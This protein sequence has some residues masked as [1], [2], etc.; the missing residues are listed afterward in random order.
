MPID[1]VIFDIICPNS[2]TRN[3]L[4]FALL[5]HN[6][7]H[8]E[9]SRGNRSDMVIVDCEKPV[10]KNDFM[11]YR[12]RFPDCPAILLLNSA[13]DY[14]DFPEECRKGKE[15]LLLK[16]FLL[17]DLMAIVDQCLD[18]VNSNESGAQASSTRFQVD[19]K[20]SNGTQNLPQLT[21]HSEDSVAVK[22]NIVEVSSETNLQQLDNNADNEEF[23]EKS[24]QGFKFDEE[25][26]IKLA[27]SPKSME[28][29]K[30][31]SAKKSDVAGMDGEEI[32]PFLL[33]SDI[34]LDNA[35]E[36]ESIRLNVDNRL[37]GYIVRA[38]V[39]Q[40][41]TQSATHLKLQDG[42]TFYL[43]PQTNLLTTTS[44]NIDLFELAQQDF[45]KQQVVLSTGQM[46]EHD[47]LQPYGRFDA[48]LWKLA[49]YTYRGYLP[50]EVNVLEPVYLR[51]WPNLTRFEPTPNAMRISALLCRQPA[52]LASIIRLLNIPQKHVFSFYAAAST[53]GLAGQAIRDSD[54]LLI[55]TYPIKTS[56]NH[57]LIQRLANK[58]NTLGDVK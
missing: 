22:E 8:F 37:L 35:D 1:K 4:E 55:P 29:I 52:K 31:S 27:I 39:Q 45:D 19:S 10:S 56:E 58:L 16:P 38:I 40:S 23:L 26:T 47:S 5:K 11:K 24:S 32:L 44:N 42:T 36:V 7:E 20:P 2:R 6:K 53:L 57:T 54:R 14:D 30:A 21:E 28:V 9:L 49:L 46:P 41:A 25:K 18:T 34:D 17:K 15:F 3:M 43:S 12:H 48:Y 33:Q 51:Y 50:E 13:E